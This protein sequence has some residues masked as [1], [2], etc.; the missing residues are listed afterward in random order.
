MEVCSHG[1]L[2]V[3]E[4]LSSFLELGVDS[5]KSTCSVVAD[6][7]ID[8]L[9]N[10]LTEHLSVHDDQE[11]VSDSIISSVSIGEAKRDMN[12]KRHH[13]D[14]MTSGKCLSKSATFPSSAEIMPCSAAS[15]GGKH[16]GKP[17][18]GVA[19]ITSE[20]LTQNENAK[21]V[22]PAYPR[23]ISL[24][25]PRKLVSALKGS[26]EKQ[27]APPKKLTVKWAPDVYDPTPTAV[28]HVVT[29]KPLRHN[30]K[31]SKNKQKA[32]GKNSRGS[33]SKDKKQ[34]RKHGGNSSSRGF[35]MMDYE[36]KVVEFDEAQPSVMD[37]NVG[38]PDQYCGSSF[39]KK[40]V[41]SLHFSVAEAT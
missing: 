11:F 17:K 21:S 38:N 29:N 28:S 13:S 18:D 24:P 25:T 2:S 5:P 39:L 30:K 26:R 14:T 35:K 36:E 19:D 27:G 41:A 10:S 3:S 16:E 12:P 23:S 9:G 32:G 33:K 34:G 40:S 7:S 6:S 8:D 4:D 22:T 15:L 37:F 20:I 31:N 1:V